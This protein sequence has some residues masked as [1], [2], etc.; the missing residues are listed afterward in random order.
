MISRMGILWYTFVP[1]TYE[2][3]HILPRDFRHILL[4]LL[5]S[6]EVSLIRHYNKIIQKSIQSTISKLFLRGNIKK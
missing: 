6:V 2:E 5:T 3:H 1:E 4:V